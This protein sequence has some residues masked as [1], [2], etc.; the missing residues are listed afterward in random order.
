MHFFDPFLFVIGTDVFIVL[1]IPC[2]LSKFKYQN[3]A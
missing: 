3:K 2:E 1:W